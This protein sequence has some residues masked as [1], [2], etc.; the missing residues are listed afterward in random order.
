VKLV[1]NRRNDVVAFVTSRIRY[2]LDFGGT[3]HEAVGVEDDAGRIRAGCIYHLH[4]PLL[5]TIDLELTAAAD[6]GWY[7]RKDGPEILRLGFLFAFWRLK[8][9]RVTATVAKMNKK[10]RR[11]VERI[12][13]QFVGPLRHGLGFRRHAVLY[14]MAYDQCPYLT[15]EDRKMIEARFKI[16]D[17]SRLRAA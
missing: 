17:R 14:G 1:I 2:P 9:V 3:I 15:D 8:A 13:F 11:F 4:K 10:S 5:G 6:P 12:G 7:T 16:E